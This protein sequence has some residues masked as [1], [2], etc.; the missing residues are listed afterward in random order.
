[1]SL[2]P[3]LPLRAAMQ[4]PMSPW[5]CPDPGVPVLARLQPPTVFNSSNK[6]MSAALRLALFKAPTS[7]V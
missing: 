2:L 5:T 6:S 3:G 7:A 4:S 1:M